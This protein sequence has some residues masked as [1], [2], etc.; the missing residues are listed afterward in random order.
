MKS[1]TLI[2]YAEAGDVAKQHAVK[3]RAEGNTAQLRQTVA[4]DGEVEPCDR[5]V[6][7]PGVSDFDRDRI[8]AAYGDKVQ[9]VAEKA[10]PKL[11][12]P[13]APAAPLAPPPTVKGR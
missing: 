5:V 10:K 13:P 8:H 7:L 9:A 11:S 2:F 6:V 3:L 4:F 1:I 12:L